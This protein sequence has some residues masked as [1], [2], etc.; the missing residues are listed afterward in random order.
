M[1]LLANSFSVAPSARRRAAALVSADGPCAA[2]EPSPGSCLPVS[3]HGSARIPETARIGA[4][5]AGPTLSGKTSGRSARPGR[6][7]GAPRLS[8]L[9]WLPEFRSRLLWLIGL[10]LLSPAR[11]GRVTRRLRGPSRFCDGPG[12]DH[13]AI[14]R[15]LMAAALALR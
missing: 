6:G 12:M 14:L 10:W 3:A 2:R 9:V 4:I 7:A 11:L 5:S 13:G 1:A 15:R 8:S